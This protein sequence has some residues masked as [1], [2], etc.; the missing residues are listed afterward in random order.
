MKCRVCK[1]SGILPMANHSEYDENFCDCGNCGG[2]GVVEGRPVMVDKWPEEDMRCRECNAPI[3]PLTG[4]YSDT[5]EGRAIIAL[6]SAL[7]AADEY[8][9]ELQYYSP[10]IERSS[11]MTAEINYHEAKKK[12]EEVRDV[13]TS[14]T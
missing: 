2:S 9:S 8:I 11:C 12:L 7:E 4:M 3:D 5:Q 10:E 14:G 6:R 1:G 13:H